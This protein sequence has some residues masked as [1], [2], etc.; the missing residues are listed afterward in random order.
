MPII[1]G[2]FYRSGTSLVRRLLDSHSHIHCGPEVKFFKDFYGDYLNDGLHHVRL[3]KTLA[4]LGLTEDELLM[5]FGKTFITAHE[6]A[7]SKAGKRRWADKNP[8]NVLYL[9]HWNRLIPAG[10]LFVNVV[11]NPLDALASLKEIG[12][13]KAVPAG[14]E[15]KARLY[16]Q[17][18]QIA[19]A[20][21][22][23]HKQT[24]IRIRYE[25]LTKNP[26]NTLADLFKFLG[27]DYE[28]GVLSGFFSPER[29]AGIEDPKVAVTRCVHSDSVGRWQKVLDCDEKKLASEILATVLND[30]SYRN[31]DVH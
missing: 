8:E 23:N 9:S 6:L 13:S 25:E 28:P 7:A 20:Y 26:E 18:H 27:E 2:G 15:D 22:H 4:S 31:A 30:P 14:F 1:V 5:L 10:F 16:L 24:C 3:F 29:G 17:Y 21:I 12:F 19:E 11:R